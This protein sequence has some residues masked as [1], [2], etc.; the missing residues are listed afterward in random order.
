MEGNIILHTGINAVCMA[1]GVAS[2]IYRVDMS[3]GSEELPD[4]RLFMKRA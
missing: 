1:R 3:G 4:V 2:V